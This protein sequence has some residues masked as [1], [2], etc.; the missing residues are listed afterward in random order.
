MIDPILAARSRV[1]NAVKDGR[2]DDERAARKQLA[3]AKLERAVRDALAAFPPL[4]ED[5]KAAIA[6][7]LMTGSAE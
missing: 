1:A 7:L 2:P 6:H 5:T 3:E 4:D